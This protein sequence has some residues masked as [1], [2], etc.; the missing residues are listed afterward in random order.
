[1]PVVDPRLEA[2]LMET[3]GVFARAAA[4]L[5][6]ARAQVLS[7]VE[8]DLVDLSLA[9][10]SAVL[11]REI[12]NDPQLHVVL[13]HAA[14]ATIGDPQGVRL[15]A[16]RAAHEAISEI[17]G[18]GPLSW[19]GIAVEVILDETL[20]GLGVVAEGEAVRVDARVHERLRAILRAIEDERLRDG[21]DML[22]T[23]K[24]PE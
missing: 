9:I 21:G 8:R 5:A 23:D 16:S 7:T 10:A 19:E 24:V 11:E 1:V 13:A 3:I 12:A 14:L 2:E 20:E 22:P 4:S 6:A 15:R 18:G 17:T